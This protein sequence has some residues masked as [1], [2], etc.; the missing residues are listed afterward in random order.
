[1]WEPIYGKKIK[2]L[3]YAQAR[4]AY[5]TDIKRANTYKGL[6]AYT[7]G[8]SADIIKKAMVDCWEAGLFA[9]EKIGAP[10]LTVHD[11]L[12]FS[13]HPDL[14]NYFIEVQNIMENSTKIDVP[15]I[16]ETELGSNWGS[17]KKFNL[18]KN[19]YI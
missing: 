9:S 18:K 16:V 12:D 14:N 1:M 7:Q 8:S 13:Y 2:S 17:C 15:I 3:P 5:G 4:A 11:E 6:N 19:E 10:H